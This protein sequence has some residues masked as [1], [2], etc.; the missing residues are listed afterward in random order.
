MQFY[1]KIVNLQVLL[2]RAAPMPEGELDQDKQSRGQRVDW[3]VDICQLLGSF[4][5]AALT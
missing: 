1:Y 5:N 3:K 2:V 4:F